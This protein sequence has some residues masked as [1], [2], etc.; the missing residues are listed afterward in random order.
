MTTK[1]TNEYKSAFALLIAINK[2]QYGVSV[3]L[4]HAE[5]VFTWTLAALITEGLIEVEY[6]KTI[7][8]DPHSGEETEE[9]IPVYK[10]AEEKP[11]IDFVSALAAAEAAYLQGVKLNETQPTAGNKQWVQS[12]ILKQCFRVDTIMF[13][14]AVREGFLDLKDIATNIGMGSDRIVVQEE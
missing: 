6:E 4:N 12:Q 1:L 2:I 9:T 7:T 11:K 5:I 10:N 13:P 14:I 3:A 8:K